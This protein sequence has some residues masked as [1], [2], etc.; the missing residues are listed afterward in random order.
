MLPSVLEEA[1]DRLDGTGRSTMTEGTEH[2]NDGAKDPQQASAKEAW[3][4]VGERFASWGRGVATRYR[5]TGTETS[6]TPE[7]T[8]HKLEEAAR[9]LTAELKRGF[10]ALGDTFR[11]EQAKRDLLDAVTAVGDAI[12]ATVDEAGQALRR[13]AGSGASD[14]PTPERPDDGSGATSADG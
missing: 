8:Q 11:D 10:G 12:T 5:D 3:N 14:R 13:G 7:E 2:G 9:Q 4:A 6:A 1:G